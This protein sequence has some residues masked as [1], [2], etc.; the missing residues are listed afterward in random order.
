MQ[1]AARTLASTLRK[2][3]QAVR[4]MQKTSCSTC[5]EKTARKTVRKN[6]QAVRVMQKTSC[7]TCHAKTMQKPCKNHANMQKPCNM[8]RVR[9]RLRRQAR[10]GF[11]AGRG[12]PARSV[13]DFES[14]AGRGQMLDGRVLEASQ[15]EYKP[16][17]KPPLQREVQHMFTPLAWHRSL[18]AAL[19]VLYLT[20]QAAEPPLSPGSLL[21][22]LYVLYLT[23]QAAEPPLSPSSLLYV[24][25]VL[26]T[27]YARN[28]YYICYIG[29]YSIYSTYSME[30][31]ESGCSVAC[32]VRYSTYSTYSMDPG[33][34]GCS[35]ACLVRY[36]TYSTYSKDPAESGCSAG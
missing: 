30:L 8:R 18:L 31:G 3:V 28:L 17:G 2:N 15:V 26:Y 36:S 23:R 6:V 12:T 13:L 33:G 1:H 35:V 14:F 20:R 25:Y 34:S 9:W 29:P 7:S 16:F 22:V 10:Q 24:L 32:L 4:V 11:Y 21:Y 19:Y 5:H 27:L